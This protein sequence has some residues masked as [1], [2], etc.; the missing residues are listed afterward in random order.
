M[1]DMA[2]GPAPAAE[3]TPSPPLTLTAVPQQSAGPAQSAA[4]NGRWRKILRDQVLSGTIIPVDKTGKFVMVRLTWS[5]A[6]SSLL[7]GTVAAY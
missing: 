3:A 2:P 7:V 5:V 4:Q 6:E 1:P